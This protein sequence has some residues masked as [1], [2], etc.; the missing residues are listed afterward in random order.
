[1]AAIAGWFVAD[2]LAVRL[3][4]PME[5]EIPVSLL[6]LAAGYAVVHAATLKLKPRDPD[7]ELKL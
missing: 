2:W 5:V 6:G 7:V 1:V 4:A 3:G